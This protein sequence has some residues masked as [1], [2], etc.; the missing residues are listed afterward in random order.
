MSPTTT[1]T[2]GTSKVAKKALQKLRWGYKKSS[3]RGSKKSLKSSSGSSNSDKENQIPGTSELASKISMVTPKSSP[4]ISKKTPKRILR[5]SSGSSN[6][7]KE[8]QIPETSGLASKISSVSSDSDKENHPGTSGMSPQNSPK[9]LKMSP[10]GTLR[11]SEM[12]P[13]NS[14]KTPKMGPKS[15]VFKSNSDSSDSDKENSQLAS[16][17]VVKIAKL[18][19]LPR[20]SQ[21]FSFR[22]GP[23]AK[24][25]Y[26][27]KLLCEMCN[28]STDSQMSLKNH[29]ALTCSDSVFTKFQCDFCPFQSQATRMIRSHIERDHSTIPKPSARLNSKHFHKTSS[30]EEE[31]SLYSD[32]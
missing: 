16:P 25:S 21:E 5:S 9:I 31:G 10:N 18:Q 3:P 27:R 14:P 12:G 22:V 26:G 8:N 29:R 20:N 6:S 15:R 7:D 30:E 13:K 11:I 23:N 4:G 28:F 32:N 1:A 17:V 19:N 2:P 24:Q